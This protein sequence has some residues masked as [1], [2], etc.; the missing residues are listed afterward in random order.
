[1]KLGAEIFFSRSAHHVG[2]DA[3]DHRPPAA[4]A[5][6]PRLEAQ[7]AEAEE[8]QREHRP[9]RR[10]GDGGTRRRAE[11][12]RAMRH[13]EI[14]RRGVDHFVQSHPAAAGP[15]IHGP[16][17]AGRAVERECV[18]A[19]RQATETK[20][21]EAL[22]RGERE[23]AGQVD[24]KPAV[25]RRDLGDRQRPIFTRDVAGEVQA[26]HASQPCTIEENRCHAF[27]F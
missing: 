25:E 13:D 8:A 9:G 18:E 27:M 4:L 21:V 7:A 23:A 1:V 17:R 24:R 11:E 26:E 20:D 6:P 19:A 12:R 10:F 16:R 2:D 5:S 15:R 3:R 14:E 22:V